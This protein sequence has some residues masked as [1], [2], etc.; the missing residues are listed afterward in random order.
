M[1]LLTEDDLIE[2]TGAKRPFEQRKILD[3]HGIFYINKMGNEIS[4]TWHHV[5]HPSIP[6]VVSGGDSP[7][8]DAI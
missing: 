4:T 8:F 2:L 7:D 6:Q 3:A 1:N 5:N